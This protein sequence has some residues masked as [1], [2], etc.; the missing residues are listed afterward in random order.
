MDSDR[1][2]LLL[3]CHHRKVDYINIEPGFP[4][5]GLN[6]APVLLWQA[7]VA[8]RST[9]TI[10]LGTSHQRQPRLSL[11][12]R[13]AARVVQAI[14]GAV[15]RRAGKPSKSHGTLIGRGEAGSDVYQGPTKHGRG[16]H[17]PGA[18]PSMRH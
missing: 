17:G 16:V 6:V 18:K 3:Q 13:R 5:M 14:R 12:N 7:P 11:G 10:A 1:G 15:Q 9:R 2:C 4:Q 8:Q